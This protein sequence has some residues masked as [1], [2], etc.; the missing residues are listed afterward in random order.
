MNSFRQPAILVKRRN[1]NLNILPRLKPPCRANSPCAAGRVMRLD[2]FRNS[3]FE[4]RDHEETITAIEI[5]TLRGGGAVWLAGQ[6]TI[7]ER[8]LT[9][10]RNDTRIPICHLERRERS[11]RIAPLPLRIPLAI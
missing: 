1:H 4:S 2:V 6:Q 7:R 8:F 10:A 11:F 9:S 3:C 5:I